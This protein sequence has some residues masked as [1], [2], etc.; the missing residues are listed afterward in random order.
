MPILCLHSSR[1]PFN[2]AFHFPGHKVCSK[3]TLSPPIFLIAFIPIIEVARSLSTS[4]L[5][6]RI[7][8]SNFLEAPKVNSYL[9]TLWDEDDS[10]EPKGWYL[11]SH[12][13]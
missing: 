4:G 9:Y 13:S 10:D 12:Y 5:Q 7:P 8:S 6:L 1:M 2:V 3:E 11:T